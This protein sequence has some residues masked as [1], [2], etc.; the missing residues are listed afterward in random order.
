MKWDVEV[1]KKAK[2]NNNNTST[3]RK[4]IALLTCDTPLMHSYI[5]NRLLRFFLNESWI[6][7]SLTTIIP[8]DTYIKYSTLNYYKLPKAPRLIERDNEFD[9]NNLNITLLSLNSWI[10]RKAF[11]LAVSLHG[12]VSLGLLTL[13][14]DISLPTCFSSI[15]L[16]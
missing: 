11:I 16:F 3:V 6:H 5:L 15:F 13:Y 14:I 10:P 9:A 1:P 7:L 4:A 2:Y 8:R 12:F